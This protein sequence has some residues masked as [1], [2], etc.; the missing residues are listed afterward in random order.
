[1]ERLDVRQD[2]LTRAVQPRVAAVE[3]G[4]LPVAFGARGERP[5]EVGVGLRL[6]VA[7]ERERARHDGDPG[8]GQQRQRLAPHHVDERVGPARLEPV[9]ADL[10]DHRRIVAHRAAGLR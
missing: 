9:R 6:L 5:D 4:L 2:G 8:V 3:A 1:M 7:V 10:E